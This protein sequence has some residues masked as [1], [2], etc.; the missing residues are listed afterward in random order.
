MA[1]CEVL[2]WL[3]HLELSSSRINVERFE[4]SLQETVVLKR[5]SELLRSL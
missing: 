3:S 1:L 4:L 5:L 2:S